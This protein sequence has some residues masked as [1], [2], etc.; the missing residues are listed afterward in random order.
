MSGMKKKLNI[1]F[2][3]ICFMA[4]LMGEAYCIEVLKGDLFSTVGIG[5]VVLITGYLFIDTIISTIRQNTEDIKFYA[6]RTIREEDDKWNE[7]FT[8]IINLQKATYTATKKNTIMLTQQMKD[9]ESLLDNME[10]NYNKGL[11]RVIELQ[12]LAME[13]QKNALK[14]EIHYNRDNAKQVINTIHNNDYKS[15]LNNQFSKIINLMESNNKLMETNIRSIV[16]AHK[17]Q[18]LGGVEAAAI[19][20]FVQEPEI[21]DYETTKEYENTDIDEHDIMKNVDKVSKI[22]EAVDKEEIN[23]EEINEEEINK[24]EINKEE[25]THNAEEDENVVAEMAYNDDEEE[26]GT[27]E[28]AYNA[29]EDENMTSLPGLA[30]ET[31]I[32]DENQAEKNASVNSETYEEVSEPEAVSNSVESESKTVTPLYEDPNKQLSADEIAALFASIGN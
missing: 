14:M 25:T 21:N 31:E 17:N 8:E 24:E 28:T 4:A 20:K 9:L 5:I 26:N 7:R 27:A 12:K 23:E 16:D 6:D 1:T 13:G 30:T 18:S 15:E 22:T 32:Y 11:Q 3:G 10:S 2:F 29:E 19:R